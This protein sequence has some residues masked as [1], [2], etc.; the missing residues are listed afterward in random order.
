MLTVKCPKC[1]AALRMAQA[2]A[3]GRVKC[4]KC[5]AVIAVNPTTGASPGTSSPGNPQA[6][7]RSAAP[8]QAAPRPSGTV[9]PDDE[10]FDFGRIAF[11]TAANVAAVSQ[12]PSAG[13]KSIYQG[14]IPGDPLEMAPLPPSGPLVAGR[15]LPQPAAPQ[16][17]ASGGGGTAKK[18]KS[19]MSTGAMIRMIV[20]LVLLIVCSVIGA[21]VWQQRLNRSPSM[22]QAIAML[23]SSAPPGYRAVGIAGVLG[24][25]PSGADYDNLPNGIESVA[26]ETAQSKS[27]YLIGAIDDGSA[28][29]SAD[30]MKSKA[31][32][33]FGGEIR[34]GEPFQRNGHEGVKGVLDGSI[35]VPRMLIELYHV[36][37]RLV[38]LGCAPRSMSVDP[39]SADATLEAAEQQV[40]YDNFKIQP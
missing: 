20:G 37:G 13:G 12:F 31:V 36:N 9:D 8:R 7:S 3:G 28:S 27:I 22:D 19:K 34:G 10:N 18:P 23:Q 1:A 11:P 39:A 17:A 32:E 21:I 40:F 15:P 14:P 38:I 35:Y 6:A 2:P 16:P 33:A 4:P 30:Q 24:M 5:A 26:T 29:M 25:M